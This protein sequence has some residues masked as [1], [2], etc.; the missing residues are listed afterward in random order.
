MTSVIHTY[1]FCPSS[2]LGLSLGCRLVSLWAL[3]T[4]KT[5]H[6]RRHLR[7]LGAMEEEVSS[8]CTAG[9]QGKLL[10]TCSEIIYNGC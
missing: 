3:V 6:F 5:Q 2:T 1:C 4:S 8:Y 10:C 9:E 7:E